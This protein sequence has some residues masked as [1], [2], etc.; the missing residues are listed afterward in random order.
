[1]NDDNQKDPQQI[2]KN[3]L[4][5]LRPRDNY[6]RPTRKNYEFKR[7]EVIIKRRLKKPNPSLVIP[8][9]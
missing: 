8:S 7:P 9:T 1:M 2:S 5:H 6:S 3:N 4:D